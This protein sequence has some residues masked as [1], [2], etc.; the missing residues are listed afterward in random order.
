MS[1]PSSLISMFIPTHLF[2][3]HCMYAAGPVVLAV[4]RQSADSLSAREPLTSLWLC[5]TAR[6][7]PEPWDVV[8][9]TH[10]CASRCLRLPTDFSPFRTSHFQTVLDKDHAVTT[11]WCGVYTLFIYTLPSSVCTKMCLCRLSTPVLSLIVLFAGSAE[12]SVGP[13]RV[14]LK[15]NMT[16]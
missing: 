7:T 6:Y 14:W 9:E 10:S 15:E 12:A 13:H 2:R 4:W 3:G 1:L 16:G 11:V 8:T 5:P